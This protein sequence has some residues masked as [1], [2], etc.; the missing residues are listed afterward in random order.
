MKA[1]Q[2]RCSNFDNGCKWTGELKSLHTHQR[3]CPYRV[4]TCP[5]ECREITTLLHKDIESHRKSCPR[6]PY[7]CPHCTQTGPYDEQTSVHTKNCQEVKLSNQE[8]NGTEQHCAVEEHPLQDCTQQLFP[9]KY[10]D[11]GCTA[12]LTIPE[13][14]AHERDD[15]L[16]LQITKEKVLELAKLLQVR[17]RRFRE[18]TEQMDKEITTLRQNVRGFE[19]S[20]APV[21]FAVSN[22]SENQLLDKTILSPSF[23]LSTQGYRCYLSIY[24]KGRGDGKYSHVSVF[25]RITE[26]D[27]DDS[28]TRPFQETVIVEVLNQLEDKN[29]KKRKTLLPNDKYIIRRPMEDDKEGYEFNKFISHEELKHIQFEKCQ[30]LKDDKLY[31]RVSVTN[32]KHCTR[33]YL[34]C[35]MQ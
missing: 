4:A 16:H 15:K 28:L 23:Y 27:N 8:C 1:L 25:V 32:L 18:Q 14:Q 3:D 24:P 26:E 12:R 17:E 34:Y 9:C 29:H 22:F 35:G 7:K 19:F 30:Y 6:R 33:Y 2:I 10:T 11:V 13:L 20:T 5:N 31:F 21:V